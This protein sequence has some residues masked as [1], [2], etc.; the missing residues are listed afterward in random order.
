VMT[1]R[2]RV[3]DDYLRRLER[4]L[5]GLPRDRRREIVQEIEAHIQ[6]E[7]AEQG[8]PTDA[9]IHNM[10]ERIGDPQIIAADARERFGVQI[11]RLTGLEIA[12]VVFLLIGGLVIPLVGWFVGVVLLWV[13]SA[14]TPRDKLIGTLVVPGG[15]ALPAWLFFFGVGSSSVCTTG[16][17]GSGTVCSHETVIGTPVVLLTTTLVIAPILTAIYL[18]RRVRGS[19][20]A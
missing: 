13:S 20:G 15:L 8:S 18:I 14:W 5:E 1:V 7:I 17:G 11:R 16:P 9:D 3:V 10:L 4:S 19:R 12:A 2:N 6:E